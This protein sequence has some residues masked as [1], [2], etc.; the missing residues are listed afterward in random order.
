MFI[1]FFEQTKTARALYRSHGHGILDK[2][3]CCKGSQ[4]NILR[5]VKFS[6]WAIVVDNA[7]HAFW[8]LIIFQTLI[9]IEREKNSKAAKCEVNE[10]L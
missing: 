7:L 1:S 10:E 8:T 4:K 9:E 5:H 6:I 3:V 2:I